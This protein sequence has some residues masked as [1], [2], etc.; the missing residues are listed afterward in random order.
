LHHLLIKTGLNHFKATSLI[1]FLYLSLFAIAYFLKDS[2]SII[3]MLFILISFSVLCTE[4]ITIFFYLLNR[5]KGKV[6]RKYFE[7]NLPNDNQFL[8]RNL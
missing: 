5:N 1:V 2:V 8:S 4:G 7:M 6:S 3:Q